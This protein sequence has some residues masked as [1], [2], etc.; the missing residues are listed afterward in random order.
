MA[1]KSLSTTASM[2]GKPMS[3]PVRNPDGLVTDA[4]L[5][6]AREAA[7]HCGQG[8]DIQFAILN[9]AAP[10]IVAAARKELSG[11]DRSKCKWWCEQYVRCE[12]GAAYNEDGTSNG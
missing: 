4:A 8:E 9:A 3:E 10:H 1:D 11:Q 12:C 7:L 5:Q 2:E 6:A